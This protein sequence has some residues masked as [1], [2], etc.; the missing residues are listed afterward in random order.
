MGFTV[1]S[2]PLHGWS[3]E[4]IKGEEE[5]K[6]AILVAKSSNLLPCVWLRLAMRRPFTK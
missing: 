4:N 6:C 3:V 2:C 5:H 1:Y